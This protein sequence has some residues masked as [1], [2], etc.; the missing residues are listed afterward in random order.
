MLYTGDERRQNPRYGAESMTVSIS[1]QNESS[2]KAFVEKVQPFDFSISGVSI[3]TNINMEIGSKISLDIS[4]GSYRASNIV[5][6]VRNVMNQGDKNRY[7]LQF[8][9]SAND[10]MCSEELEEILS[11]IEYALKK[12]HKYPHRNPYRRAKIID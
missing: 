4:K 12:N 8:D 5:S 10:Y 6:I 3:K 7:G 11:N 1:F 2:G 9:F